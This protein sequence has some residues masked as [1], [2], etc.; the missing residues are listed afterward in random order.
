MI[1]RHSCSRWSRVHKTNLMPAW[2][3]SAFQLDKDC[4]QHPLRN[5]SFGIGTLKE[6]ADKMSASLIEAI[7][8]SKPSRGKA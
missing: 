1:Y 3:V 8:A 4:R 2:I 7:E 6:S 5:R